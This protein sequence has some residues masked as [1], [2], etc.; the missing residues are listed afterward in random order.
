V[1]Q[2]RECWFLCVLHLLPLQLLNPK[3]SFP[4]ALLFLRHYQP[5]VPSPKTQR[6]PIVTLSEV[7]PSQSPNTKLPFWENPTTTPYPLCP[8]STRL[9][10]S[11]AP[12]P[13]ENSHCKP[14]TQ[15]LPSIQLTNFSVTFSL[16]SLFFSSIIY[17]ACLE[18]MDPVRL[19]EK[20]M[21]ARR[22]NGSTLV[23]GSV[24]IIS[25]SINTFMIRRYEK[26]IEI[27]GCLIGFMF[28]VYYCFN[29]E[30]CSFI[31]NLFLWFQNFV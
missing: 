5:T 10:A 18:G 27:R 20:R 11:A 16:Y 7:P 13:P 19:F 1:L 26:K 21:N 12:E 9:G 8:K 29:H 22:G 6:F 23:I 28:P 24:G 17:A 2:W 15:S 3:S 31:L 30:S 4:K 14:L 25:L